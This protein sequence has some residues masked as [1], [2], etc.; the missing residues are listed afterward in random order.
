MS[1]ETLHFDVLIVGAGLS[2]IGAAVHLQQRCPDRT[3]AVLEGRE[4]LG[5]TWDLFRYPGIRSDSDMHTLGYSFRPWTNAKAIA[6]GADIL[7]YIRD[8][9]AEHGVDQHIRYQHRVER[10]RWSSDDARWTVD[11]RDL[12]SD[13]V[14]TFTCTFLFACA[15][16]YDYDEGYTPEFKGIER[17][18]GR[19][20]HPQR[21]TPDIAWEG[22]RVVIIGSGATAITLLPSLAER[23]AHVTMLQRS[24]TYIMNLPARDRVANALRGALPPDLAYAVT[25]WKNI[26][27]GQAFYAYCRRFPAHAKRTLVGLVR[28]EVGGHSDVS[29]FVPT[30][31]PWDQRLCVV[32]DGDLFACIR[33][34]RASVVTDHIETFTET[35]IRLRSGATLDADLVVT[36]TGLKLKFLGGIALEVDGRTIEPAE[37]LSYKGMMLSDVP[38]LALAIGY[39]NASWTLKCDLTCEYV[40]RVL[41]TLRDRGF[42]KVVPHN[43]D[44]SVQPAPLLDFTAGYVLRAIE[45]FPK[46]GSR[47]PWKLYQN[48]ALDRAALRHAK[49]DDGALRFSR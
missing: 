24:P 28:R 15:G 21:W 16:Y 23:A 14:R 6:D 2:G 45:R 43:D 42:R 46:Q 26:T 27:V 30:Y 9:A 10:A 40:C 17:F 3:Y 1:D 25:R 20:V 5:G 38:N 12:A 49:L 36:A 34:G 33:D 47:A 22:K 48:Y 13:T 8:T 44:P 32:P 7:A 39:T 35:G 31:N 4:R 37:C 11:V 18:K 19:V 41:N 29:N